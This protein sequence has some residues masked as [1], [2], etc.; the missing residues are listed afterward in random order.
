MLTASLCFKL[1]FI[2]LGF[3]R[4]CPIHV[5]QGLEGGGGRGGGG[6]GGLDPESRT[7]LS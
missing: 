6:E 5:K 3:R 4:P 1:R 7:N 2:V